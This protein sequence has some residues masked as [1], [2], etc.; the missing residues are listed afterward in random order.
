MKGG[1]EDTRRVRDARW[2]RFGPLGCEISWGRRGGGGCVEHGTG[3]LVERDDCAPLLCRAHLPEV[4][5][6]YHRRDSDADSDDEPPEDEA[7]G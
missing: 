1:V 2:L 6:R 4:G 7:P 5:R 3:Y